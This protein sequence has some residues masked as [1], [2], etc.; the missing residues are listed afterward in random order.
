MIGS[1]WVL[2]WTMPACLGGVLLALAVRPETA[3]GQTIFPDPKSVKPG[4]LPPTRTTTSS[5][6]TTTLPLNITCEFGFDVPKHEAKIS[7]IVEVGGWIAPKFEGKYGGIT[8]TIEL[9][10]D[11]SVVSL[12]PGGHVRPDVQKAYA[13]KGLR[14]PD[15]LGYTIQWNTRSVP[16]GPRVLAVRVRYVMGNRGRTIDVG[17]KAVIIVNSLVGR[18]AAGAATTIPPKPPKKP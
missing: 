6:T 14:V 7:G 15:N 16:D 4:M 17:K 18:G 12:L 13:L 2:G 11:G 9:L 8:G 1:R 3:A 5:S 10:V